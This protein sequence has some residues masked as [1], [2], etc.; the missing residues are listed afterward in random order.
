MAIEPISSVNSE[1][2]NNSNIKQEDFIKLFMTQLKAQDPL[3]PVNN[4]DFLVQMAQFSLLES[5]RQTNQELEKIRDLVISNQS[6]GLIGKNAELYN[7]QNPESIGATGT[8]VSVS[9]TGSGPTVTLRTTDAGGD[10]AYIND[11]P[12][13]QVKTIFGEEIE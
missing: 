5:N 2:F 3:E 13:S 7:A 8:I 10:A 4:Q 1:S 6:V 11:V 9:F 12:L